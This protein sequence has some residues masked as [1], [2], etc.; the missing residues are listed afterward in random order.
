V[1]TFF[2]G[3]AATQPLPHTSLNKAATGH[4]YSIGPVPTHVLQPAGG[5]APD[6]LCLVV[7]LALDNGDPNQCGA[8]TDLAV[9]IGDSV[10]I[11]YTVTTNSSTTL[12]YR[13]LGDDHVGNVFTNDNIALAPAASYQYNRTITASTN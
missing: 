3:A 6:G 9:S 4:A 1:I 10:N 2:A 8:A 13:T 12:N 5:C 11:C 7:T